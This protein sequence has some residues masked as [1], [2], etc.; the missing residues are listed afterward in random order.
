MKKEMFHLLDNRI[1]LQQKHI[2]RFTLIL[3]GFALALNTNAQ[4]IH[5]SQFYFSPVAINPANTGNFD[6]SVRFTTS[7]KNQWQSIANP[8]KSIFSSLDF[9]TSKQKLGIGISFFNDKAGKSEYALTL[10]DFAISYNVKFNQEHHVIMGLQ[11]GFGQRKI[12]SSD[13]KWDNQY[14][15]NVYD[16]ALPTGET[17]TATSQDYSYMDF[18]AGTVWNYAVKA[19][20]FKSSTGVAVF[21][22]NQPKEAFYIADKLDMKLIVHH[23]SRIRINA[24]PVYLEPQVLIAYQ[25]PHYEINAGGLVRYAIALKSSSFSNFNRVASG[26]KTRGQSSKKSSID[27]FGGGQ[28]RYRDAFIAVLGFELSESL[29]LSYSYDIN[30]SKLRV[31]SNSKGGSEIALGYKLAF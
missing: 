7:Y 2:H 20:G 4:D 24:A 3:L 25:G 14:N 11:Y 27:I 1:L 29:L 19:T 15:G 23:S 18:S 6:G 13:L 16:A 21:H 28:F 9:V 17:N 30:V 8:Y 31:A 12:Q 5:F 22:L 26:R 10:A